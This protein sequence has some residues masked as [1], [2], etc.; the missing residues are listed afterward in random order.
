MATTQTANLVN[1]PVNLASINPV[2]LLKKHN[3]DRYFVEEDHNDFKVGATTATL[4]APIAKGN[5]IT[6]QALLNLSAE[7]N[8]KRTGLLAFLA[9]IE[10]QASI[11]A[12]ELRGKVYLICEAVLVDK[13]GRRLVYARWHGFPQRWIVFAD[14]LVNVYDSDVRVVRLGEG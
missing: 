8:G 5:I 3:L 13:H 10:D 14:R 9:F 6:G 2:A 1:F 11:P 7:V 12:V 4:H